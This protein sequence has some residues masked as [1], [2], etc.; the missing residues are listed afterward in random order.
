[1]TG[2]VLL[3]G[4]FLEFFPFERRQTMTELCPLGSGSSGNSTLVRSGGTLSRT[5]LLVDAGLSCKAI[6]T[7]LEQAGSH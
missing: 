7:A 1:M 4:I 3:S 6:C 2:Q 5:T